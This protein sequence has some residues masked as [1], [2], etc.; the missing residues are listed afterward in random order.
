MD[1]T[2]LEALQL[3]LSNERARLRSAKS[4]NEIAIRK[5]FVAQCEK[6]ITGEFK[7]LGIEDC[8]EMSDDELMEELMG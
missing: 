2:H 7:R 3:R 6:E 1:T 8:A 5:V 4:K